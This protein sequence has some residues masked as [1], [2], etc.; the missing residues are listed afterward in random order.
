[1]T[2]GTNNAGQVAPAT[3]AEIAKSKGITVYTIGVGT[4]GN[5][6]ITDPYGF[7]TTTLE[8]KIDEESLRQIADITGGKFYRAKD[9]KMLKHVFEE[10]DKL[11]KSELDVE[12]FT[13]TDED[14]MPWILA[15]LAAYGLSMLL[16][17]TILRRIP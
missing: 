1:L 9:E 5:I 16:R 6:Q 7:S 10:I 14:F 11:E 4:H 13:R 8:T 3:A 15:A 2:D 12:N 17:Y